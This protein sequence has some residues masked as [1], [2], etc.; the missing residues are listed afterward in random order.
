MQKPEPQ[1]L[2]EVMSQ[3]RK[4]GKFYIGKLKDADALKEFEVEGKKL[5]CVLWTLAH[6]AWAED[7]LLL[8]TL[9][10]PATNIAWLGRFRTAT[11]PSSKTDWPPLN[12]VMDG[13]EKVHEAALKFISSLDNSIL[14]EQVYI[15]ILDWNTDKRHAIMHAIRHEGVHVGHLSWLCKLHGIKTI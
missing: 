10:G 13:M 15:K 14:D 2:A 6:M 5:N 11:D 1:I 7:A 4:L 8:K 9:N 12:E 3:T